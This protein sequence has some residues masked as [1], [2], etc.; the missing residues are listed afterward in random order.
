MKEEDKEK[1]RE[2]EREREGERERE[3]EREREMNE[4]MR[5]EKLTH[6][7]DLM[8]KCITKCFITVTR[9]PDMYLTNSL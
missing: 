3:R 4:G 2:R 7:D 1:K 8:F 5:G 9:K 6:I